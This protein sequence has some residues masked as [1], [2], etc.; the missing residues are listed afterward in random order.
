MACAFTAAKCEVNLM[1]EEMILKKTVERQ[2]REATKSGVAAVFIMVLIGAMIMSNI[3]FKDAFLN[4]NLREEFAPQR[5]QAQELQERMN[6]AKVVRGYIKDRMMTLD[7][8]HELY[9]MTP[10]T[11][12]LNNVTMDEDGTVTI[13]GISDSMSQVFSYVKALDDSDMFKRPKPNPHRPRKTMARMWRLLKLSL[14]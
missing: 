13:D 1:P 10:H 2:S 12:Y 3:Y 7:V 14:K 6:K 11:I 8:I 9:A 5:I 4:K